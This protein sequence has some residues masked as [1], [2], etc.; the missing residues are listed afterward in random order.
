MLTW[1]K[2]VMSN[3]GLD[4]SLLSNR[5]TANIDVFNKRTLGILIDLPAPLLHGNAKL[6]KQNSATVVNN[7]IEMAFGWKD[8]IGDVGY[9]VRGNLTYVKNKVV[10]YKGT[11]RT[12]SGSRMLMEGYPIWV[13]YLR[14]VDRIVQTDEDLAI[15]QK[16]IDDAPLDPITGKKMNPFAYG[17]PQKGDILYKDLNNDGLINDDDRKTFG[18]G[19]S[20]NLL[21]GLSFGTSYKGFDFSVLLQGVGSFKVFLN[22]LTYNSYVRWGYQL[23]QQVVDGRWFEGRTT[24]AS[25][26]RLLEYSNTKNSIPSNMWLVDKSYLRIK[27]IQVGYTI[28]KSLLGKVGLEAVRVY[29][30]LENYFTFTKYPGIDPEVSGLDYPPTKQAVIGFNFSF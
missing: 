20:P 1:E 9:F 23:N 16:I 11:D 2:T 25:F 5:L 12:I 29:G 10:K 17:A 22:D 27:N 21:Y 8:R 13:Q 14:V 28:P 19:A 6:P 26:P 7:G 18:N 3:I 30:S 24:P 15:V 4:V